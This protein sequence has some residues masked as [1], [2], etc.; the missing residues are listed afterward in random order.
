MNYIYDAVPY[1]KLA[2]NPARLWYRTVQ[3]YSGLDL[4][5]ASDKMAAIAALTQR[6]ERL[7]VDD[8][9]LAGLWKKTLLLDLLWMVWPSPKRGRI[10]PRPDVVG[11]PKWS[12]P[13][14]HGQVIWDSSS[15]STLSSVRIVD[16]HYVCVG[17]SHM[18][19]VSEAKITLRAPLIIAGKLL[20]ENLKTRPRYY[21]RQCADG[22]MPEAIA[23]GDDAPGPL[24]EISVYDFDSDYRIDAAFGPGSP[25]D[26]N[27]F[28][29]PIGCAIM[30]SHAGLCVRR[31][32][33]HST[34]ERFGLAKLRHR[35]AMENS[36]TEDGK[37]W[38]RREEAGVLSTAI[39]EGLPVVDIT[40][41]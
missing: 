16:I 37:H 17:S 27:V 3:E 32:R 11:A 18:G 21:E 22:Q 33:D 30:G 26:I 34:Y 15:I 8:Q 7:R 20:G 39:L 31:S 29:I 41:V 10:Q 1:W 38:D 13:S 28:I 4:T 5:F 35:I 19:D 25:T 36:K 9:F 12:W 2:E 6:M 24:D 23:P 14:V 40:L